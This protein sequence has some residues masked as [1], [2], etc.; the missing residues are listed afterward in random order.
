VAFLQ[1]VENRNY[2]RSKTDRVYIECALKQL[3][4][5]YP[6]LSSK[7][8]KQTTIH[9]SF[10]NYIKVAARILSIGGGTGDLNGF[11]ATYGSEF[12]GFKSAAK[13]HP[14]ILLVDNDEGTKGIFSAVKHKTN[15]P[16]PVTGS[17]PFYH[18]AD[19]LYVVALPLKSGKTVTIEN[20]FEKS[21]LEKKLNGKA[22]SGKNRFDPKTQYGKHVFAE[23]I[24]KKGQST[25]DFSEFHEIL[26][27]IQ[28]V[29]ISHASKKI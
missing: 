5:T 16:T 26:M 4:A 3:P 22:F 2:G 19:N 24:I 10:F 15:S 14:V 7:S 23:Q 11:V 13:R 29:L 20:F 9:A 8:A 17:E 21:V 6:L 18:V 28:A 25:I 12:S 1:A 27:R